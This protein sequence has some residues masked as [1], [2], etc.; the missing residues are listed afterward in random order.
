METC[1][2]SNAL[3]KF[4]AGI[5]RSVEVKESGWYIT[6]GYRTIPQPQLDYNVHSFMDDRVRWRYK[7]MSIYRKGKN[8]N[9]FC[10]FQFVTTEIIRTYFGILRGGSCMPL[11]LD[12]SIT[13]TSPSCSRNNQVSIADVF[14]KMRKI[15]LP[16]MEIFHIDK[17][18]NLQ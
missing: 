15:E 4:S 1:E 11:V 5:G 8:C 3:Q 7:M 16:E 13:I 2:S 12:P 18:C 10:R 9:K 17:I 6:A 14:R